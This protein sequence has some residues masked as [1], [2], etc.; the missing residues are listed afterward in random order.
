MAFL[1]SAFDADTVP[2]ADPITPIP[3]GTYQMKIVESDVKRA[4][5]GKGDVL[6]LTCEILEGPHTGRKLWPKLSIAHENA[7]TEQIAQRLLSAI[8]H[9]VGQLKLQDTQQLH[10]RPFMGRVKIRKGEGQYGDSN[11]LGGAEALQGGSPAPGGSAPAPAAVAGP[12]P[13]ANQAAPAASAL[14]AG[15]TPPW[16]R[17]AG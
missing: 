10:H 16:Q 9:A 14:A 2:P 5:S 12:A 15:L 11:D 7:Q 17:K 4:K 13:W 1:E 3:A 8:C 6:F